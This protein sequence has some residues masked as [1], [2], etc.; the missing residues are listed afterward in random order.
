MSEAIF[1]RLH[2][3]AYQGTALGRT[4]LGPEENIRRISQKYAIF[5]L[6]VISC[7]FHCI[8]F[9]VLFGMAIVCYSSFISFITAID[10][11]VRDLKEYVK[12]QYTGPRIVVSAAG[13]VD[14]DQIVELAGYGE[15]FLIKLSILYLS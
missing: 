14:H 4:I 9:C 3:T 2:E 1:D 13:A 12:T 11:T 6:Y 8:F 5:Q 7:Y 15:F 10:V